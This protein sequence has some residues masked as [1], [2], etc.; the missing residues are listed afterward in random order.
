MLRVHAIATNTCQLLCWF[1]S[2]GGRLD[3]RYTLSRVVRS[4][5]GTSVSLCACEQV[6]SDFEGIARV[7]NY[8][9]ER[10]SF[11]SSALLLRQGHPENSS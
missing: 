1:R 8:V 11:A 7:E 5:E 6:T 3:F 2:P 10:T 4:A 9:L